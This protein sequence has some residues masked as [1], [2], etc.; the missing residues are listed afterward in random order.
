[1]TRTT[2]ALLAATLLATTAQARDFTRIRSEDS[3]RQHI[4]DRTLVDE[5]GGTLVFARNG[6]I[7][8]RKDAHEV[9]GG[10]VWNRGALCA[11]TRLDGM[12]VE[13]DCKLLYVLDDMVVMQQ[14][15]GASSQENWRL[16]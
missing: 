13:T 10:W 4:A 12:V 15:R 7:G 1:M 3:F 14:K 11:R 16:R 9:S 8:G 5:F 6:G 2:L